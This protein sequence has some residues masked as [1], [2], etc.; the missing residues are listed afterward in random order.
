[1]WRLKPFHKTEENVSNVKKVKLVTPVAE[2]PKAHSAKRTPFTMELAARFATMEAFVADR[3]MRDDHVDHL[4]NEAVN[5]R[6]I[7]D[8]TILAS[9]FCLWDHKERRLNGQHTAAMRL[10]M[11]KSWSPEVFV[12]KYKAKTEREFRV[13]YSVFDRGRIRTKYQIISARLFG[14]K[15]YDGMTKTRLNQLAAGMTM[16]RTKNFLNTTANVD[17][18][19]NCMESDLSQLVHK[20]AQFQFTKLTKK[21]GPHMHN[22]APVIGAMFATFNVA[23]RVAWEFWEVV[24]NGGQAATHPAQA[25]MKYL[26]GSKIYSNCTSGPRRCKPVSREDMYRTCILAWNAF[27]QG[28]LV[29]DF[30][31][32]DKREEAI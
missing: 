13:L 8:I 12:L 20:V 31:V 14:T 21:N 22:R 3:D 27:R 30:P 7:G 9:C 26:M 4:V 29:R 25:L 19:A 16:W 24:L 5:G 17:E 10:R 23:P 18:L 1:M 6:F 11:P 15:L 28:N 2:P 32:P